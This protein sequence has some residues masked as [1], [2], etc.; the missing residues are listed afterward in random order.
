M[1]YCIEKYTLGDF[2]Y[3][4]IKKKEEF[5]NLSVICN[6]NQALVTEKMNSSA[7]KYDGNNM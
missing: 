4:T 5:W 2:D 7:I 1:R 6:L 3:D